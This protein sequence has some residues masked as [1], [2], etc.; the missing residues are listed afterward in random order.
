MEEPRLLWCLIVGG[1]WSTVGSL[2]VF[3]QIVC[4]I[5]LLYIY[6]Q[7]ECYKL[8]V[9][10]AGSS[11]RIIDS[12]ACGLEGFQG[13]TFGIAMPDV[14]IFILPDATTIDPCQQVLVDYLL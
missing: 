6:F 2:L 10:G 8:C 14:K 1:S 5:Y 12:V 4:T 11:S 7:L 13:L 3:V 9:S